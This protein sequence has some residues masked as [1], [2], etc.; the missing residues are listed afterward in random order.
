MHIAVAISDDMTH[1]MIKILPHFYL[2]FKR[3][4]WSIFR[5]F[6]LNEWT[7]NP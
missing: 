4:Y 6:N 7:L 3:Q 1:I 2:S 5:S